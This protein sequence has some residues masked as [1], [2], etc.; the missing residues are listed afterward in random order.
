MD[1]SIA[2]LT[3]ELIKKLYNETFVS[4]EELNSIDVSYL[5]S[6]LLDSIVHGRA[7]KIDSEEYLRALGLS[8][9]Q[10]IGEI[11]EHHYGLVSENLNPGFKSGIEVIL[12]EGTLSERILSRIA[13]DF[14]R[15]KLL[16]VYGCLADCLA[17]GKIF[18]AH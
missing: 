15:E 14:R 13:G 16:E 7:V 2:A 3:S 11:W 5:K 12:Q 17:T 1:L 10:T 8:G 18:H 9:K 4:I 6:V